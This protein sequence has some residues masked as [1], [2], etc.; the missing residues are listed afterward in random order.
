MPFGFVLDDE[1]GDDTID[2]NDYS[3]ILVNSSW[4]EEVYSS[5]SQRSF[6]V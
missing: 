4:Y 2:A 3:F 6:L 5:A 1:T